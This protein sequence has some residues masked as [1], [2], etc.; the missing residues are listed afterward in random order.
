[1]NIT[2]KLQVIINKYYLLI[3]TIIAVIITWLNYYG[4]HMLVI[5]PYYV[6]FK[7][8]I[9]SGFNPNSGIIGTPTYPMWGYG[10]LLILT[11]SKLILIMIQFALAL[12][13][14]WYFFNQIEK[15][16]ILSK[17]IIIYSKGFLI[18]SVPW[19][20]FHSIRWP[21]SISISLILISFIIFVVEFFYVNP[22]K[23]KYKR[24]LLSGILFGIALNF[25]S[26]YYLLP[27]GFTIVFLILK[28]INRIN[29]KKTLYWL[30]SIYLMLVPWSIYTY[31][32]TSHF[33]LTSTNSG[34][35]LFL[36][37]GAHPENYWNIK[38]EDNDPLMN[39][40]IYDKF[41]EKKSTLVYETNEFLKNEFFDRVKSNPIEYFRKVLFSFKKFV[42][43][44]VYPGEFYKQEMLKL[45]KAD[46]SWIQPGD[47]WKYEEAYYD[48]I[49]RRRGYASLKEKLYCE[50]SLRVLI[51]HFSLYMGKLIVLL[52]I[53]LAPISFIVSIQRN[54]YFITFILF[55]IAYQALI[56]TVA[57]NYQCYTSNIYFPLLINL[58]F[59][60]SIIN[61]FFRKYIK[62]NN[63]SLEKVNSL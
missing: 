3:M 43:H 9:L 52:S 1:M 42:T 49:K 22:Q 54:N 33:L 45:Q 35:V 38:I 10:W 26:D 16:K 5:Y 7:N 60:I 62:K 27:V 18:I 56:N 32:V 48:F 47:T 2:N 40:L 59:G 39:K 29:L 13:S 63:H 23:T 6:D 37:L 8:I 4:H 61:L 57:F 21:Y 24:I 31:S 58:I 30:A 19:Y 50:F 11:E 14:I 28:K 44:G 46:K 34:H 25:R 41:G 17:N 55:I 36:G 53:L 20:V 15:L 51:E 12:F